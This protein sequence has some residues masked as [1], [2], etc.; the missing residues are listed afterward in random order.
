MNANG[1]A[2]S[3]LIILGHGSS[4]DAGAGA[5][6]YQ[7]AAELRRRNCFAEVREAFWKQSPQIAAVLSQVTAPRL[8]IV[9]LFMSEGYFSEQVIPGALGFPAATVSHGARVLHR[10]Q[11]AVFYTKPIGA[12]DSI[13]EVVLLRATE[14]MGESRKQKAESRNKNA[15]S[16]PDQ[17]LVTSAPAGE[18]ST[19]FIAGHGTE[20]NQNSRKSIER[21]VERIRA[22][23]LYAAVEGVF[24]DESPRISECYEIARTRNM[25]VVPFFASD[26]MH[27]QEDIPVMLGETPEVV[28]E[29]IRRGE[30]PVHNPIERKGKVVWYAAT[31]G[32]HPQIAEVILERA[33]EVGNKE[34]Q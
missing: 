12:H 23:K 34:N 8:F 18:K 11:Q 20:Q 9:P 6:V 13:T 1:F 16:P 17:S 30:S 31:V 33:R 2:D 32:T 26:G 21:Q 25:V 19:L 29:R 4:Q 3:A 15:G 24:L 7:H 5:T 10:G 22:R 27:T 28:R 14:V